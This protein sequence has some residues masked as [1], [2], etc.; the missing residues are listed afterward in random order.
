MKQLLIVVL[1]MV[2][3]LVMV[4]GFSPKQISSNQIYQMDVVDTDGTTIKIAVMDTRT[5][6]IRIIRLD[7]YKN[8]VMFEVNA[9]GMKDFR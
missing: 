7:P 2:S 5:S 3:L 4:S 1:I 9:F 6:I 8:E